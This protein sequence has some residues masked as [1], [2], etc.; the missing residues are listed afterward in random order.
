M[1]RRKYNIFLKIFL[2]NDYKN[3][4]CDPKDNANF[5]NTGQ[6]VFQYARWG[7]ITR[8]IFEASACKCCVLTNRL[9]NHTMIETLF[10]HNVSILYYDGPLSLIKQLIRIKIKP[11]L[12]KKISENAYEIVNKNH[13]QISRAKYLI[14]LVEELI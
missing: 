13:T 3:K 7:E 12:V 5:F 2:G 4:R 6:V 9:K 14:K 11:D 8:R 1:G 10:V